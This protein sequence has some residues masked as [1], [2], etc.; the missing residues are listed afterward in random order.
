MSLLGYPPQIE[1]KIG[2]FALRGD[3]TTTL[4]VPYVLN[5]AVS[6]TQFTKM[7]VMIKNVT[8]G[9]VKWSGS[10]LECQIY[11]ND[12][13]SYRAVFTIP[14]TVNMVSGNYYKVQIAF[15]DVDGVKSNWSNVGVVKCTSLPSVSIN[16]LETGIDNI[17]PDMFVGLYVNSDVT[18]KVYS[19][20][21]RIYDANNETFESSGELIH[22]ASADEI[23][24]GTGIKSLVRWS[25]KK[26]LS[27]GVRYR[28]ALQI[29]TINGYVK[30]TSPYI[31]RTA[32]TVDARIPAKLL[33]TPDYDNGCV[34]LSLIK[35]KSLSQEQKF[36]GNFII[37]R[38]QKDTNLW[39]EVCRFNMLSQTPTEI[40]TIWTDYTME[41]GVEYLYALQ[42]Y[43]TKLQS[44]RMYHVIPDEKNGYKEYDELGYP[45]YIMGDFE[46]MFLTD[47]NRQLKIKY[48]P[49]VSSYKT[50][51]LETKTDTIGSKY[52][53]IFRN[54]NVGYKEFPISGLLSYLADDK[55]LF[56]S[57]LQ[58]IETGM[59]RTH[60]SAMTG[61]MSR[62][63]WLKASSC[64]TKLTSDNFYRERQFKM[65]ALQWLNNGEPKL[66][67]SP[68]E[69]SYIVRL[70]NVSLSPNDT[71]G[72]MLHTFSATAYEIADYSFESLKQYNLLC[73]PE[74][75]NRVMK[76]ASVNL[77]ETMQNDI[78]CPN[79][80]MYH[81]Y[82][83]NASPGTQYTL[84]FNGKS[85]AE[86]VTY[87][88]GV[89][90]AFYL[91]TD[92][93]PVTSI[94]KNSGDINNT[95]MLH[96]G[97]YDTSI[98]NEFSY[99]YG[100][101]IKDEAVQIIGY[102]DTKNI[103][104]DK[105]QDIRREVGNFYSLLI[106]PRH[107]TSIYKTAG[108]YFLDSQFITEITTGWDDLEIYY[109]VNE[110]K[111]YSGNPNNHIIL[112]SSL[113]QQYFKLNDLYIIDLST[114]NAFLA[115]DPIANTLT[116]NPA[117]KQYFSQLT[118]GGYYV[119]GDFGKIHSIK[120]SSGVY[121]ELAYELKE[122][123]YNVEIT[124]E[125]VINAKQ[126]WIIASNTYIADNSNS[127]YVTMQ[128]K[129]AN[130]LD[131]LKTALAEQE[132]EVDDYVL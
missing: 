71:V 104:T 47:G 128:T 15:E 33:A 97:Y 100:V 127:N 66:F 132:V 49:K 20:N 5:K 19:Y 115:S 48:N 42:A 7:A 34:H 36:S 86:A 130:Y 98:P 82:I 126:E 93:L 110:N 61:S 16:S 70:M 96:Y 59:T 84:L 23:I 92:A 73:L 50:T 24:T 123:E 45:C 10:T 88:I 30:T 18:E 38:Y 25:P 35:D 79:Y 72:R 9:T 112:G 78:Y 58:L 121:L 94:V 22:N 68:G 6:L 46:D 60:T 124:E 3:G 55:E 29:T 53:F 120:A 8:T 103:I 87:T 90:G 56:M 101:N 109:V 113:P 107:I 116:G 52:P 76:F 39:H 32:T 27:E 75:E 95:A 114:G 118:Y 85:D 89:T 13:K 125:T 102:D 14:E 67:R 99:I 65:E 81:V 41:H 83:T 54:G 37:S 51:L 77:S 2:A 108:K 43:N 44:N 17:N 1:S 105:L 69:G 74:I 91:D 28:I 57:G 12:T 80:N 117:A 131:K 31:I 122:I 11:D 119:V 40:G 62:K 4:T 26:G 63:D 106:K 129:Y 64:G 111:Y 21:F